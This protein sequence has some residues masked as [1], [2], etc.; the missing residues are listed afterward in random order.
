MKSINKVFLILLASLAGATVFAQSD[1]SFGYRPQTEIDTFVQRVPGAGALTATVRAADGGYVTAS[2]INDTSFLVRKIKATG[3]KQWERRLNFDFDNVAFIRGIAQTTDGGFVLTGQLGLA[4]F[5][6]QNIQLPRGATLVKLRPN[7]TVAW[8]SITASGH[9]YFFASAIPMPDGGVI[10]IGGRFGEDA[11]CD[12]DCGNLL[13]VV[14]VSSTGEVVWKKSFTT[15]PVTDGNQG[16][17]YISSTATPDN[18]FIIAFP[19]TPHGAAVIKI[20]NL[21]NVLW[22]KSFSADIG[23]LSV[24]VTANGGIIL[25]GA[26]GGTSHKLKVVVLKTNGTLNWNAGYSLK[27]PGEI[28]SVSSPVQT[29]DGG[30]VVTGTT[31]SGNMFS[32]FVAKIDSSRNIAFQNTFGSGQANGSSVFATP[33]GGFVLFGQSGLGLLVSKVNAEGIEPGC[34]FFHPLGSSTGT[35]FGTLKIGPVN[36]TESDLSLESLHLGLTSV[37]TNHPVSSVCQ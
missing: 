18:G 10:A 27:V 26:G 23:V 7:G 4:C 25:V 15:L 24:G 5:E 22:K 31:R 14:R 6:C 30:Y 35:P 17:D 36:L 8:K 32:G 12:P 28:F 16:H 11:E 13:L 21:G 19:T 29:L 9:A 34:G 33:D 3:Q 37:V 20:D 2:S 1:L